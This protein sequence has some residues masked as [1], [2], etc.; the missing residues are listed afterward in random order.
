MPFYCYILECNDGTYYAGWTTDPERRLRQHNAGAGSRY[1][2]ARL[3][4][5]LVYL[6]PQADRASAL[7]R[8]RALKALSHR[9]KAELIHHQQGG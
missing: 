4:V 1:T 3:P 8:E 5:K 9:R 7:K 6:E 2:R